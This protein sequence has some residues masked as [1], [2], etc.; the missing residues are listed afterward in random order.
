MSLQ[1]DYK[2]QVWGRDAVCRG[3]QHCRS[4]VCSSSTD[5]HWLLP[6]PSAGSQGKPR[7]VRTVL[8]DRLH[9]FAS[10]ECWEQLPFVL[11]CLQAGRNICK[12][13]LSSQNLATHHFLL[14]WQL[15]GAAEPGLSTQHS[16]ESPLQAGRD[17]TLNLRWTAGFIF[18][19]WNQVCVD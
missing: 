13:T 9:S 16:L 8:K 2:S 5:L 7:M 12:I 17:L 6:A 14:C 15:M 18:N 11:C 1:Q 19:P 3:L 10:S 4:S